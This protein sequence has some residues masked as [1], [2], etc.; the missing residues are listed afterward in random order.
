MLSTQGEWFLPMFKYEITRYNLF[1]QKFISYDTQ[2]LTIFKVTFSIEWEVCFIKKEKL[3]DHSFTIPSSVNMLQK[4]Q[5][6]YI[7]FNQKSE[8][9]IGFRGDYSIKKYPVQTQVSTDLPVDRECDHE[10]CYW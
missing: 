8:E 3:H 5:R 1:Y 2:P 9:V 10:N 7:E 6:L 4:L